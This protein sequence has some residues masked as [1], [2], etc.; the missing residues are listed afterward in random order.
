[1]QLMQVFLIVIGYINNR[2]L[3][4]FLLIFFS[5]MELKLI[6][7]LIG[8]FVLLSDTS[9]TLPGTICRCQKE[10]KERIKIK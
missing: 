1:M 3:N 6:L 7:H 8:V 9:G 10:K 2:L 4:N 5:S